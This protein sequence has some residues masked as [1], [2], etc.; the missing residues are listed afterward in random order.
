M[1]RSNHLRLLLVLLLVQQPASARIQPDAPDQP[2]GPRARYG[3]RFHPNRLSVINGLAIGPFNFQSWRRE[4]TLT[5]N[6]MNLELPGV[7]VIPLPVH[8][9][10]ITVNGLDV[11]PFRYGGSYH[12]LS[13][14]FMSSAIS[15]HGA[16]IGVITF[17]DSLMS[18]FQFSM[19]HA[20]C[21]Q[22]R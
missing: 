20:R 9:S 12:G 22:M 7:G 2:V 4:S 5:V 16:S 10:Y 19:V 14:G 11:T 21:R 18:G 8:Y 13:V 17:L 15:V 3:V 1:I 6:G